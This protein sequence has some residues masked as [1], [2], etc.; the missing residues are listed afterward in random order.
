MRLEDNATHAALLRKN[1]GLETVERA[2]LP[3]GPGRIG[4][5]MLVDIDG[6]D[7]RRIGQSQIDGTSHRV[8]LPVVRV[9][10]SGRASRPSAARLTRDQRR[11][12]KS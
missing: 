7:E 2:D 10:G 1:R 4:I 6:A 11:E 8:D 12:S 3:A 5:K 9:R